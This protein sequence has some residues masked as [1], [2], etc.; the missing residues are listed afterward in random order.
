MHVIFPLA[1]R[2]L[3]LWVIHFNHAVINFVIFC[4]I[5]IC[6]LPQ[7][8]LSMPLRLKY[9]AC[10]V[11]CVSW[12]D[13][14]RLC[15]CKSNILW[16]GYCHQASILN[17]FRRFLFLPSSCSSPLRMHLWSLLGLVGP[18]NYFAIPITPRII[19]FVLFVMIMGGHSLC[20]LMQSGFYPVFIS[21]HWLFAYYII[22]KF[23]RTLSLSFPRCLSRYSHLVEFHHVPCLPTRRQ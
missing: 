15:I 10:S 21:I 7:S 16:P 19:S 2:H 20:W 22:I 13:V 9:R 14:Y 1:T 5:P 23:S 18:R 12:T 17:I 6:S 8:F 4:C 11:N 3:S